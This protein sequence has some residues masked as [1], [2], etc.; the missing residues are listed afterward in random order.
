M[1]DHVEGNTELQ[2]NAGGE[3]SEEVL[4]SV[5]TVQ[6]TVVGAN[7]GVTLPNVVLAVENDADL[8]QKMTDDAGRITLE[9]PV[10][11]DPYRINCS[12]DGYYDRSLDVSGDMSYIIALVPQVSAGDAC[13][14]LDWDG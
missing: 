2:Q 3:L 13:V 7:E 14:L 1:G 11:D 9:L 12:K 4:P 5:W 6:I 8:S 10:K